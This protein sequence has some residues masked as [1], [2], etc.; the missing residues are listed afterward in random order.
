M[1]HTESNTEFNI[2]LSYPVHR[3]DEEQFY[4]ELQHYIDIGTEL[5]A[6]LIDWEK[7]DLIDDDTPFP[8][9]NLYVPAEHELFVHRAYSANLITG[10]EIAFVNSMILENCD[11]LVLFGN[12]NPTSRG[13]NT[14]E[15]VRY[16]KKNQIAIYT[17]PD[18]SDI[19]IAA[20]KFAIKTIIKTG[21]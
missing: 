15:E 18:L 21:D 13:I 5:Q 14:V 8:K 1:K 11:L 17:M 20:L 3:D 16:A 9:S 19:A 12:Y 4:R 2:Y 6:Y 10:K 7:M